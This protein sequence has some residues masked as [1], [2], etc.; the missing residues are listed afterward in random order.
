MIEFMK[1][2]SYKDEEY[3]KIIFGIGLFGLSFSWFYEFGE[4][5]M[6]FSKVNNKDGW[7]GFRFSSAGFMI[8]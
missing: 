3:G 2:F 7:H 4:W 5:F 8:Y 6:Y 1:P